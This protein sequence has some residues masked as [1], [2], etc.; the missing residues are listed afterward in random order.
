MEIVSERSFR[1][2]GGLVNKSD[3]MS[4][5]TLDCT[6]REL[7]KLRSW[8]AQQNNKESLSYSTQQL[9]EEP[10]I[11]ALHQLKAEIALI[12]ERLLNNVRNTGSPRVIAEVSRECGKKLQQLSGG[13]EQQAR[14]S[15]KAE[16]TKLVETYDS[17]VNEDYERFIKF[18]FD[19]LRKL[20]V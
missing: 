20:S 5:V 1:S 13:A 15:V 6:K 2:Q 19:K 9:C 11:S 7:Y 8:M 17:V 16:I 14:N 10:Q 3:D 12:S 4:R 18:A